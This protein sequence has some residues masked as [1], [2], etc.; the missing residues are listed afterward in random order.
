MM[1]GISAALSKTAMEK[2]MIARV[3]M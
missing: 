2:D 1:F 3:C